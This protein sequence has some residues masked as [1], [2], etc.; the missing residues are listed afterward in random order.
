M[1]RYQGFET[2]GAPPGRGRLTRP[3]RPPTSS[4][5]TS[6]SEEPLGAAKA[7]VV[8]LIAKDI[9]T[10]IKQQL[11]V[12]DVVSS[13]EGVDNLPWGTAKKL[14]HLRALERYLMAQLTAVRRQLQENEK[15]SVEEAQNEEIVNESENPG[16]SV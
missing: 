15:A 10:E 8:E 12:Q 14:S 6:Q 3:L 1:S 5:S 4:V 13:F 7:R 2:T 16:E 9:L 11:E